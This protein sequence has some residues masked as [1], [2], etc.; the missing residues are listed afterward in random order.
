MSQNAT[1]SVVRPDPQHISK[2]MESAEHI[3]E[4]KKMLAQAMLEKETEL[5]KYQEILASASIKHHVHKNA[6]QTDVDAASKVAA[7]EVAA[8]KYIAKHA[9]AL[10][11]RND[12]VSK[13]E[14]RDN[15]LIY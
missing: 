12:E 10:R 13:A 14:A 8:K 6:S 7:A 5:R 3:A 11:A 1:R 4:Q 15:E 2:A 9:K